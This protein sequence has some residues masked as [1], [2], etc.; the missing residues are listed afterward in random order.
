MPSTR[1]RILAGLVVCVL[2]AAAVSWAAEADVEQAMKDLP[3]YE[4]GQ[5]RAQLTLIQETLRAAEP[6]KRTDL[7]NRLAA[8]L[9]SGA[10]DAAKRWVCRQLSIFGTEAQ[11]PQLAPLLVDE[12]LSD[13]ARYALE[14]IEHPSAVEAMRKALASA[15]P[16]QKIGLI[17][18][19]G[20]RRDEK[21]VDDLVKAL[22]G[23]DQPT[24]TAAARALAKIGGPKAVEAL[25][26]MRTKAEGDLLAVVRDAYL[27]CADG[28]LAAGKAAQAAEMYQQMYKPDLPKHVRTAALRGIV[29]AGGEKTMPLLTEILTGNDT[30]MQASA[31]RFLREV[32]G[33]EITKALTD[34]LPKL[35]PETQAMMLADLGARGDPAALPAVAKAVASDNEAVKK[36]AVLALGQLGDASTLPALTALAAGGPCADEARQALDTLPAANVNPAMI[37]QAKSAEPNVRKEVIRS[38]GARGVTAAVPVLVQAARAD[39]KA[40]RQEAFRSLEKLA[41]SQAVPELVALV[42]NPKDAEDRPAAQ[43]ALATV[44][45]RCPEKE[46]CASAMLAALD[47]APAD[48]KAALLQTL[49]A[50]GTDK[51]LAALKKCV[52]SD[53]EKVRDAAIRSLADWPDPAAAPDLLAIAQTVEK[54]AHQV[55]ALRGYI[56]LAGSE[57]LKADQRLQ[58]YKDAMAA[59]KRP[60]EKKQVLGGLGGVKA[61]AAL[62]MVIPALDDAALQKEAC[63]AAVAIAK[64]LGGQGKPVIVEAMKKVL[65]ISKDKRLNGEAQT[66]LKKAGG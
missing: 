51:A 31:L 35:P 49:P 27:Q 18:S 8:L 54:T 30:E 63:A 12:Q 28:L 44:A 20:V 1:T 48:A 43:R 62:E 40:V 41:G 64:N 29:A 52:G 3:K 47:A 37:E 22:Q 36:A 61:V 21:A 5:S 50:A 60:D 24:A 34:L 16:G 53:D 7:C 4:F 11:V 14:R 13:M 15:K 19:L 23:G 45:G 65:A 33:P 46:A 26:D 59:A 56:R 10:T 58:M 66:L 42:V 9:S 57:S 38:L 17:N 39:D 2:A 25:A 6:A 55:L 32:A